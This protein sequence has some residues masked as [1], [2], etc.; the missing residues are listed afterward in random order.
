MLQGELLRRLQVR[1][2][3]SVYGPD[4]KVTGLL[5]LMRSQLTDE[6]MHITQS[7]VEI[8]SHLLIRAW[9]LTTWSASLLSVDS[10]ETRGKLNEKDLKM[11]AR[12]FCVCDFLMKFEFFR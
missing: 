11:N 1:P 2:T 7:P 4:D 9:L 6:V 10:M 8:Q 12:L 3:D 5:G